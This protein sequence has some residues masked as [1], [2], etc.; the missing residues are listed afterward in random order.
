MNSVEFSTNVHANRDYKFDEVRHYKQ[1][2]EIKTSLSGQFGSA[3]FPELLK[4]IKNVSGEIQKIYFVDTR[5][6]THFELNGKPVSYKYDNNPHL[7]P[8]EIIEREKMAAVF[9]KGKSVTFTPNVMH[10]AAWDEFVINSLA[11]QDFIVSSQT[12][13]K[14]LYYRLALDEYG[15]LT[16]EQVETFMSL[17]SEIKK[18]NNWL[19]INSIVGG[20]PA[21]LL[22]MMEDILENGSKQPLETIAEKYDMKFI[23]SAHNT[24]FLKQP[25]VTQEKEDPNAEKKA[26]RAKFLVEFYKFAT[27]RQPNQTWTAWKS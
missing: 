21:V 18:G 20:G 8:Q 6:D 11:A 1:F 10:G 3:N 22:A 24:D 13:V 26:E 7:S 23:S 14:R 5:R 17:L 27:T 15:P 2:P 9:L 25:Q 4:R 19:H 16:A 12:D